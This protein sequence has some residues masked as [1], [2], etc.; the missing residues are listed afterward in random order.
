MDKN[1]KIY[2][3]G[4]KGLVGSAIDRMLTKNGYSNIIRKTHSELDLRDREKVFNFFE[5]EKPEW[6]FLS[7]AKVGGIYA[8]N[9]YPVDFLLYNLQIQNSIIEASYK[10]NVK[11]LMFL[12]SSCIYPKECPQ[13]IKE[14]YLLSGYLE[15]TN[16]PYALAKI[17]GI[18]LC[19]AYNRQYNTNYIAVMPCNLYGINDNYHPE[20]AH[21][22]PMLIRRFHEAKIN[23]LKET[24]IWGSGTPLREFMSSDDLAEACIYLMENKNSEDIGKFIN[25][26]SGKEVA[27]KELAELIKKTV[28]FKG[29]IKLDSS[30]PDGTMRKL[31]DVS[32]INSL[33]W[34]YKIELEDGLKIAYEDFLKNYNK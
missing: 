19:D 20:N 21:V 4:H 24:V 10:Y 22:I 13:P 3:A 26:G 14:E 17:A 16:Q 9:T 15:S 1:I 18:E 23:D 11:K 12:G 7:A 6:V 32:K 27:I 29:E 33:G 30:K 31:L 28:G 5:K 2:I 8:N 34:K 25:I